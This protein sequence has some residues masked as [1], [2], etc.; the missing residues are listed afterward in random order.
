MARIIEERKFEVKLYH[1]IIVKFCWLLIIVT[2]LVVF[3]LEY[4]ILIKPRLAE[5]KNGGRYDDKFYEE[6]LVQEKD[7]LAKLKTFKE[8]VDKEI[9]PANLEKMDQVLALGSDA[10]STLNQVNQLWARSGLELT[11]LGFSLEEGATII[12][13]S[14]KGSTYQKFKKFL[15]DAE[16]NIRIMD[17]ANLSM[18]GAGTN[19]SVTI[20]T[21]SE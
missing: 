21:Y 15:E 10:P 18:A 6:L 3:S 17:I 20:K 2:F 14:F 16:K 11:S 7:Y 8:R 4:L 19:F 5:S 9:T 1:I 13:L 12:N